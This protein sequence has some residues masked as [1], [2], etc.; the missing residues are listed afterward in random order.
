MN[1][2]HTD[3]IKF[4]VEFVG[5]PVNLIPVNKLPENIQMKIQASG[6]RLMMN[7]LRKTWAGKIIKIDL[8]KDLISK[9]NNLLAISL[10]NKRHEISEQLGNQYTVLSI[11]PDSLRIQFDLKATRKVPVAVKTKLNFAKGYG[12]SGPMKIQPDSITIVGKDEEI[13]ETDSI[14]TFILSESQ[15]NKSINRVIGIDFPGSIQ[16]NQ[17]EVT[18]NIPVEQVS[19]KQLTC[20]IEIIQTNTSPKIQLLH[21]QVA[22]KIRVPN[23]I[24]HQI[25]VD[26]FKLGVYAQEASPTISK[27]IV[28]VLIKPSNVEVLDIDPPAVE[29]LIKAM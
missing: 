20:P 10:Q 22:L 23:S 5:I 16:S 9:N 4:P 25:S 26:D 28:R 12:Q 2:L 14:F 13:N 8:G 21:A 15:I 19:E 3:I 6:Y 29:Y 18:V 24:Y 27:L 11:E 7:R 1:Q 17:T